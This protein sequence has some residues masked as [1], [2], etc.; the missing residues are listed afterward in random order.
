MNI[1][2]DKKNITEKYYE[3]IN[4]NNIELFDLINNNFEKIKSI[5]PLIKFIF[6]RIDVV[7]FLLRNDCIWDAE[8]VLRSVMETL[9]KFVFI[10]S[11]D[12]VEREKRLNE[13]WNDLSE[14]YSIKQSEQA[15]KNLIYFNE[16][17]I[18][19]LAYSPLILPIEKEK[20]LRLKWTKIQR[21][22]L[23]QKWS[24]SGIISELAKNYHG[25]SLKIIESLSHCY[26]MSSH[27]THGDETGI[28]IIEERNSR[29][30]KD[31]NLTNFAH[32]LRILSDCSVYSYWIAIEI[33]GYLGIK[34]K[35][36]INNQKKLK[37][38]EKLVEKYQK[39]VFEDKAYDKFK[40]KK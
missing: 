6:D 24:F 37:R 25:K 7:T 2:K 23:E 4:I 17:E 18:H 1:L 14:V 34:N 13:F 10:T 39:I 5:F 36:I 30:H 33:M 38:I 27:I 20:E 35:Y 28:L 22:K 15:K 12:K 21:H 11:A 19:N 3:V 29:D 31:L 16:S 32:Y 40:S 26:R 8:I 9:I